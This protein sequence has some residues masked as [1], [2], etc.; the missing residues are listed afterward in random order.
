[1][2][3][4]A[5]L[6]LDA[7]PLEPGLLF[8]ELAE[9]DH[10]LGS[11]VA[12]RVLQVQTPFAQRFELAAKGLVFTDRR[13]TGARRHGGSSNCSGCREGRR[14]IFGGNK[15]HRSKPKAAAQRPVAATLQRLHPPPIDAAINPAEG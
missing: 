11:Q 2:C 14:T 5:S 7:S 3:G 4:V 15:F 8:S 9:S 13:R 10:Q 1:L 12:H 6:T